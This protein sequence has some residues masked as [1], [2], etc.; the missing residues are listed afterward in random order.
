VAFAARFPE[1]HWQPTE[2]DAIRRA[3]IDAWAAEA[4]L[5]NIAAARTLDACRAGWSRD[6]PGQSLIVLVNLLH[7]VSTPEARTLVREAA[8]ALAPG[9]AFV[10]YGPFM[11]GHALTSEGDAR[12]HASLI[13]QDPRIGYK[14]DDALSAWL[15]EAGLALNPVQSMPANNLGFIARKPAI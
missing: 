8:Y 5:P 6:W 3:S 9:G 1:L 11:R 10:I 15:A 14:S 4:N 2:P 12:F 13:A 7:L